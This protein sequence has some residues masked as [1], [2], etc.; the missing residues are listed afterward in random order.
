[1]KKVIIAF[2]LA[3]VGMTAQVKTTRTVGDFSQVQVSQGIELNYTVSNTTKITVEA[4]TKESLQYI[5]TAVK[6]KSL[7]VYIESEKGK[8]GKSTNRKIK[9][10]KVF[11]EGPNLDAVTVSSS[12]M[13]I[14]KDALKT[15]NFALGVS[16]SGY[17]KGDI[18]ATNCTVSVSS[19]GD[20]EA[21]IQASGLVDLRSSSSADINAVIHAEELS[22]SSSSSSGMKLSGDVKSIK[23]GLSSS[24]KILAK[25]LK[26][27]EL[28]VSAS[29][30]ASGF[31]YVSE[32]MNAAAASSASIKYYG[33]PREVNVK[34]ASSGTIKKA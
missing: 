18:K 27:R 20:V 25:D 17:F 34:K 3:S 23:A 32:K 8:W 30:S 31:F 11:V 22:L 13:F 7:V 10:V 14:G 24:S 19:S 16:S 9:N 5:K 6:G 4:E 15:N 29:S 12:A 33:S 26:A 28:E 2:L 21:T 1:M